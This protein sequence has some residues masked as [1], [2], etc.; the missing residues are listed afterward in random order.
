MISTACGA[1]VLTGRNAIVVI[2]QRRVERPA[3]NLG[4]VVELL[5]ERVFAQSLAVDGVAHRPEL[6]EVAAALVGRILAPQQLA[7]KLVIQTHHVG[8]DEALVG[9]HQRD[10]VLRNLV[11]VRQEALDRAV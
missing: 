4:N 3:V 1:G 9:L 5:L 2:T 7:G 6:P 8:L 11:D 10:A